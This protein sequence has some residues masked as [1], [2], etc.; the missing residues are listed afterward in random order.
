M[1]T[2]SYWILGFIALFMA[3]TIGLPALGYGPRA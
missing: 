3:V 2:R 1:H